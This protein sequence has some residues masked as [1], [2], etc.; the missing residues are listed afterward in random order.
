MSHLKRTKPP[1][2]PTAFCLPD[3]SAYAFETRNFLLKRA[4]KK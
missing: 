2:L 1:V 3:G 4:A